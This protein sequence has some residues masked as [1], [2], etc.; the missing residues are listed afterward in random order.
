MRSLFLALVL[1]VGMTVPGRADENT[2]ALP[3]PGQTILRILSPTLLELTLI[4]RKEPDPQRVPQWDFVDAGFHFNPP[5]VSDFTVKAGARSIAVQAIGFRRRALYAPLKKRDLRLGN[6]LYLQLAGPIAEGERVEVLNPGNKLWPAKQEFVATASP[7]R[8]SPALHVNQ[9]GYVPE[10]PKKAMVGYYLGSL[11]EMEVPASLGFHL[12]DAVSGKSVYQGSLT[13]RPDIG[14]NYPRLP[15]QKVLQADFT[16]FKTPGVYRLQVPGL[17]VSFPFHIDEGIAADFARTFALGIFHQR[18]GGANYLPFTRFTHDACHLLEAEVPTMSF[19]A[20][21]AELAN[22]TSDFASNPRHTA[23][24][25]KDVNASLYPFVRTKDVDVSGGHHDAGDYSKYTINSAQLIHALV[26][27]ADAFPGAGELDNLGLP[28]SGDGKSDLLEEAKWEADFLAKMQDDDGGFYFLVY[29]RDREY[30]NDLSLLW[31]N[32]GDRQVVFPKTTSATAAAVAALAEMS[33]SP[34]FKKQFP[35]A[36]ASY[37]VKAKKGWD[38]LQRAIA[39]YGRDGS[40]QKITHYGDEFMHDDELA[41]ATTEMYLATGDPKYQTDLIAHLNPTDQNQR[42]W[43]WWRLFESYG[44]AIRSYAFAARTGRLKPEQLDSILLGQC[45]D[46]IIAGAEDQAR[47]SSQNAYGTSFPTPSKEFHNAGWYF[48]LDRAFDLAVAYQLNYP[49]FNDP[50]PRYLDAI[51]G[52]M[53]Y[54]GGCNPVNMTFVAGLGWKRERDVVSQY[55]ENARRALPPTGLEIGNIQE[56]FM[57]LDPYKKEL[58]ELSFPPDWDERNPYPFYDRWG[59]SFNTATEAVTANTARSLATTAF[60][61]AKTALKT[62]VWRCAP[63]V[64]RAVE[65][66]DQK[67]AWSFYLDV[68]GMDITKGQCVWETKEAQPILLPANKPFGVARKTTWIEAE[69]WWPDGRRAF[70]STNFDKAITH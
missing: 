23:P 36:A 37:F 25:L 12:M 22:M 68:P 6:F 65:R 62:Q 26:F 54:E 10:F 56:G 58:G 2:L 17:G 52:N 30:E 59:D 35:E 14:Y 18:C 3:E 31:P 43:T 9:E 41:W 34:L 45:E 20:V 29:P 40:Y 5:P 16:D 1:T 7:M 19:D 63:A 70:I 50:R 32:L 15:Y 33:S 66:G 44:C 60:L 53:N 8:W 67:G 47:F 24:Q 48:S 55:A 46:E 42:R 39:K 61:M 69:A 21:N 4:T 38:F 51:L 57:F 27:A 64:V 11:G 49:I 13:P 28:E